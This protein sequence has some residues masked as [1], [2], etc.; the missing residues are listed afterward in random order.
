M[1]IRNLIISL[2]ALLL[3]VA[4]SA[5]QV[6]DYSQLRTNTWS[7]Y[8][9][10][11]VATATGENL[12]QNVNQSADIFLAPMGGAGVTFNI[13]PWIRLNL[14][15]EISKYKREQ[16]WGNVQPDG[17]SYR[18]LETLYNAG[19]FDVD[20]NLAQIFRKKGTAGPFNVYLGSGIGALFDLGVDY[21]ITM[22]QTEVNDPLATNDNYSFVP[23]I[24][25]HNDLV[26]YYSPFVPVNLS[27]EYDIVPKFTLGLR[28]SLKW[29]FGKAE[30]NKAKFI[31]SVGILLRYNILCNAAGFVSNKQRISQLESELAEAEAMKVV[32]K[33]AQ[34]DL[35]AKTSEADAL[36]RANEDLQ[37]RLADCGADKAT[38]NRLMEQI[39]NLRA[40]QF[41]VYFANNSA[42]ITQEARNIIEA[43]AKRIL[44]D[45]EA[46][47]VITAS[48]STPGSEA[49]N[50][51]LS[52]RRAEAVQRALIEAGVPANRITDLISLGEEGM[53]ADGTS[54]RAIIDI[55]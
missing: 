22:G 50:K 30:P 53:T 41:T 43:A 9:M 52:Q 19:E 37:K 47:S 46:L 12:F 34:D 33:R 3:S 35:A 42:V 26:K 31:E 20:L 40:E 14:G 5:Q 28:G 1:R 39:R 49:Y 2:G 21:S 10:G 54:R 4:A 24:K 11:G 38:I 29:L 25:G 8:G 44:N 16:R 32:L 17:T 45:S 7:I 36:R 13:R 18:S 15:Y 27:I 48:C 23:W 6:S 55:K 51:L